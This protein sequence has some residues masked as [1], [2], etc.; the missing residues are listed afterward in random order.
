[1]D[2][3]TFKKAK[4]KAVRP[5]SILTVLTC[6]LLVISLVVSGIFTLFDNTMVALMGGT[7]WKLK[8][9]DPE[10]Q[11]FTSDFATDEERV[12]AG[13]QIVYQVEAEGAT[14]LFNQEE[15]LP[16]EEGA[17]VSL[18]SNSSIDIIYGGTGSANVDVSK[19]DDFMA[20]FQQSGIKVNPTLWEFYSEGEGSKY[21]RDGGSLTSGTAAAVGE[22]PWE[23]YT[24]EVLSSV[25]EYSD[26][27]VVVLSRV[28][29]EG[30]DLEFQKLNY[31]ELDANEREMMSQL[32][33]MKEDGKIDRIIVLLNTANALELDFM[34]ENEY[35]VDSV[36]WISDV[37]ISGINAVTDII[38]GV[39]NPSGSL[40]DTYC[41]DN[42]SSPAMQN[43]VATNYDGYVEGGAVP[44]EGRSYM[45]Y[46]EG[47]YVGYKYYETRYEDYVMGIGNAGDYI[48]QNQVAYPFGYGL[49]Y[50]EF[51]YS[52]MEMDYD[53]ASTTY[54]IQVNV[55][56][57][58]DVPGK[59]A[60][61][62][63][64]SS[65]YTQYDNDNGV[66][67]SAVSL[68]GFGKTQILEPGASETLTIEVDGMHV[69]SYDTY[70]AGTY[71]LDAGDYYFTAATD[72]HHAVNNVLSAKGYTPENTEGRMDEAGNSELVALW[73][74][75]ELDTTTYAVSKNGTPIVNQLSDADINLS[76]VV[77]ETITYLSRKD[78]EGTWPEETLKIKLTDGLIAGLQNL[79]YDSADYES[80]EMP[81]LGA[82][83][84]YKLYDMIGKDYDDPDWEPLLD[85]MTF[86]EMVSFIG[87]AFHWTMPVESVQAPGTRDENGPQGLTVTLFG[88]ALDVETTALT[89]EDVMAATMN[90]E[91]IYE[92]GRIVGN[93]CLEAEIPVLYGP[94]NNMHRTP[95]GGRNFEYYSE[96][97][98]LSGKISA[99]EV[100]GIQEKG[101]H[102]VMKHFA[103]NDSEQDRKGL[104]VW[105]NEQAARE[106]YLKAFQIP[107]EEGNANGV[108]T[109]YT[110]W[111]TT[112]SAAHRGL[113]TNIMR[114]EWGSNGLSITDNI[115]VEYVNGPDALI[116]GTSSFDA[117]LWYIVE[118]LP[119]YEDDPV[120]VSAMREAS[121]QML[122]AITNS[123][124]MNGIG[125]NTVIKSTIPSTVMYSYIGTGVCAIL[126]LG[127][128]MMWL[129]KKKIFK[130]SE[131]YKEYNK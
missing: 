24:D 73:N 56:N 79:L 66:E 27:A 55:T 102:V 113:M 28:G 48:Y 16:L 57:T 7:F 93:D 81:T 91:L 89:S 21:K 6:V 96:D 37:G 41:Y 8:N 44:I 50:S 14:L 105:I 130:N 12:E 115:L 17:K 9:E 36:L 10:A 83:N 58:G 70:G 2:K 30:I 116:A 53:P 19:A 39:V 74:N 104:G 75:P 64:V 103:L 100:T 59:E 118:Q 32:S 25:E 107:F 128:L 125:E 109:A 23:V 123:C 15:A 29:G 68:V 84:G 26:A 62:I 1:M 131:L 114:E 101:V 97:G 4:R 129:R 112:W 127:S 108:M 52:D 85:Q 87:D 34:Q 43:F 20:S 22:V 82:K 80:V 92:V 18:F 42:F 88:G 69:A 51:E 45:I 95:Y 99:A 3:K 119:K 120:M 121:H 110:R 77:D 11:Y 38:A 90:D 33:A 13:K 40:V 98:F 111:G 65:P 126:F 47:I 54:T 31:L 106:I 61:E 5:W 72:S 46:Q 49:S 86:G 122:Y 94:G 76:H 78:W 35:D 63:Y 60:V 71:I 124:G 67:K 117:M